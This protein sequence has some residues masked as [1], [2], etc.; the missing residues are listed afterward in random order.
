MLLKGSS[1]YLS[2][3]FFLCCILFQVRIAWQ[4]E[5]T[6]SHF[7]ISSR[8]AGNPFN[9]RSVE[10]GA[11]L[12]SSSRWSNCITYQGYLTPQSKHGLSLSAPIVARHL[13]RVCLLRSRILSL[14]LRYDKCWDLA[15]L[16][17]SLGISHIIEE[18]SVQVN[19]LELNAVGMKQI[20]S[21]LTTAQGGDNEICGIKP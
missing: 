2:S 8:A 11:I 12:I 19:M 20:S 10:T 14:F 17:L 15:C 9:V 4:F 21:I 5:Q 18:L 3:K 7:L 6:R 1:P 16:I 13:D